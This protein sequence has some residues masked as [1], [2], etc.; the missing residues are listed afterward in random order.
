MPK[1]FGVLLIMMAVGLMAG[2]DKSAEEIES[3]TAQK[4]ILDS[5]ANVKQSEVEQLYLIDEQLGLTTPLLG[6]LEKKKR[7]AERELAQLSLSI[8]SG[9]S[10]LEKTRAALAQ[11]LRSFYMS[12]QPAPA[13]LFATGSIH[14]TARLLYYFKSA[15]RS[16]RDQIDSIA[17]MQNRLEK[18]QNRLRERRAELESLVR[19]TSLEESLLERR[20]K[21]KA[22]LLAR[23][24]E[25]VALRRQ[26]LEGL[27]VDQN[28][29]SNLTASFDGSA[30]IGEF[31]ALKGKLTWPAQGRVIRHFG[32][33]LDQLTGTETFSPG[34]TISLAVGTEVTA[35]EGG[36][37]VHDGYLR[38]YGNLVIIDHGDGWYSLYGFLGQ[39]LG[40]R[41]EMVGRGQVIG[42][43][44]ESGSNVG[45]ALFFGIRH[46]EKSYDPIEW[47]K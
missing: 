9:R 43:S 45:P 46:R 8:D 38:G 24:D 22:R 19:R 4:Q 13:A 16:L 21:D 40:S 31:S 30:A 20:K 33:E 28:Q 2:Q 15:V 47:L 1:I 14:E 44:G 26:Y 6:R 37:I 5:L 29:L 10:D 7:G 27:A 39:I 18:D 34:I 3:L 11:N 41:G 35:V 25:D 36:R 12:Y 42:L 23:I 17:I 32:R